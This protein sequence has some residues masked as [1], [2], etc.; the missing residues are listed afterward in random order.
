M[1]IMALAS[2]GGNYWHAL[3]EWILGATVSVGGPHGKSPTDPG[4]LA[5][6]RNVWHHW[7]CHVG[8]WLLST[9]GRWLT[10]MAKKP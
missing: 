5:W 4:S 6:P 1:K 2:E 7:S 3:P 10:C 9:P 8:L